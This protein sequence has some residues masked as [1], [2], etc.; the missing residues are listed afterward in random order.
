ME[1]GVVFGSIVWIVLGKFAVWLCGTGNQLPLL[2]DGRPLVQCW[3]LIV[4]FE[5]Y[6]AVTSLVLPFAPVQRDII[7]LP[8]RFGKSI[9]LIR[10]HYLLFTSFPIHYFYSRL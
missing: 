3:N 5:V 1:Q 7:L 2:V 8:H 4:A 10:Y 6:K 9:A